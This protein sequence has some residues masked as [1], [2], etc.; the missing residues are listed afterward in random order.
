M[1]GYQQNN[2]L[3]AMP[4]H[5]EEGEIEVMAM[6]TLEVLSSSSESKQGMHTK[7]VLSNGILLQM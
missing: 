1:E 6:S 3:D 2:E 4:D 7:E 5:M